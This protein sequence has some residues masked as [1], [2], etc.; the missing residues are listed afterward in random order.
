MFNRLKQINSSLARSRRALFWLLVILVLIA[1]IRIRLLNMPLERD[2]GEFAY[3]AQM[4]LQGISPYKAAYNVTLKLPGTCVMYALFMALFGQTAVAI[5]LGTLLVNLA[6]AI[7]VFVLARRIFGGAGGVVAAGTF[8][9]LSIVPTILG[10][11]AHA[12]H[13]VM[14]P[15]VAGVLLLQ[16]LD[17]QTTAAK[18]FCAG[19]FFGLA[20]VM[21]Q[22]GAMFGFFGFVWILWNEISPRQKQWR[23]LIKRLFWLVMGG[24]LP[25]ALT[26]S[27]ITAAGDLK[28]FWFWTIQYAAAHE[29]I[30][31]ADFESAVSGL[32]EQFIAAP[33]L[34]SLIIIGIIALFFDST[35]KRW[36]FF[37]V[38]FSIFS[39][40]AVCP[41]WYFRGHYFIQFLPAAGLLVAAL[42]GALRR[43]FSGFALGQMAIPS[44]IFGCAVM[45]SLI[46]WN[47]IYFR[48][49]PAQACREIYGTNPFPEAV[50][51][52]RYLESHC[53]PGARILVLGSEPEIY[54]YSH[55]RAATGYICGYPLVEPQ[56]YA[57]NM[58]NEMVRQ[59]ENASPE[60]VVYVHVFGSWFQSTAP[61]AT[62]VF[63]WFAG[64]R[65]E[66]FQLV[67]TAEIE[68][69]Q[70][71]VYHWFDN[72]SAALL[73]P[74]ANS[75]LA[76]FRAKETPV[77]SH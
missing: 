14:L 68:L 53:S 63:D 13:F 57:T 3:G 24:L 59:V 41:G 10:L 49:T 64:Y 38:S 31:H 55:R 29:K 56:P 60:Y 32:S 70:P 34:W 1:G 30:L 28:N 52:G 46:Q 12:T 6:T 37:L 35:L 45:S 51:I 77:N 50:E 18:I 26:I 54:F 11:A 25:L 9:F 15:A 19:L 71:T 44:L 66:H 76:I 75:W 69:G 16:K 62:P 40:L 21:V 48:L 61:P 17:E 39:F 72:D 33:A 73:T 4:L 7:L 42:F 27:A 5:H 8:A 43:I 74:Q 20:T 58:F 67:G 47:G 65:R 2:E 22:T 36:R 23:R